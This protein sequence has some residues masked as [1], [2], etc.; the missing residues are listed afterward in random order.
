ML[1][2]VVSAS[3]LADIP[4]L[5]GGSSTS[6]ASSTSGSTTAVSTAATGYCAG[7]PAS[8]DFCADFDHQGGAS[9][10]WDEQ[11][12]AAPYGH[13]ELDP[14]FGPEPPSLHAWVDEGQGG[15]LSARL[16]KVLDPDRE[17]RITI[18]LQ[19]YPRGYGIVSDLHW[20][21]GNY[22]CV[23]LLRYVDDEI[24]LSFQGLREGEGGGDHHSGLGVEHLLPDPYEAWHHLKVELDRENADYKVSLDGDELTLPPLPADYMAWAAV[25]VDPPPEDALRAAIGS[26]CINPPSDLATDAHF[27]D[28]IFDLQ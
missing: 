6:S 4:E 21:R 7:Q 3:C 10:G 16:K 15:C 11:S 26:F 12:I 17:G 25:C 1:P 27:D 28:V 13:V 2:I 22:D 23:V 18:E 24:V 19:V 5:K 14:A 8:I 9:L 20:Q